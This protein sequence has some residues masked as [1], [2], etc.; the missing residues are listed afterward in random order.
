MSA[1]NSTA[2][3]KTRTT[4]R[5]RYENLNLRALYQPSK[6]NWTFILYA[7][8]VTDATQFVYH[9]PSLFYPSQTA[10]TVNPPFVFGGE[11]QYR[12]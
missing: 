2:S 9:A 7:R 8:N 12:F 1:R 10:Y 4:G 5:H 11:V 3:S 6:T